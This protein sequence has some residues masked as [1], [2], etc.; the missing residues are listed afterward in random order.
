MKN[1]LII[2]AL[3]ASSMYG[4]V[5]IPGGVGATWQSFTNPPTFAPDPNDTTMAGVPAYWNNPSDDNGSGLCANVG[6]LLTASGGFSGY[7]QYLTGPAP[8]YLGTAAG[9]PLDFAIQGVPGG[10]RN[11]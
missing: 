3:A 1:V 9:G 2:S 6:C 8:A 11:F 10:G 5:V 4:A 7:P